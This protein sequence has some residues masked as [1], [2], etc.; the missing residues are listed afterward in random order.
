M[1]LE[2]ES[3]SAGFGARFGPILDDTER[4]VFVEGDW[5]R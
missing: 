5:T 3:H 4:I 2:W 1:G